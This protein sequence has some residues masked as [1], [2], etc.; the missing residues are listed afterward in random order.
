MQFALPWYID[1]DQFNFIFFSL[2]SHP[3][4]DLFEVLRKKITESIN[5]SFNLNA[6]DWRWMLGHLHASVG[7]ETSKH[8]FKKKNKFFFKR[9]R[10]RKT[11]DQKCHQIRRGSSAEGLEV[12]L[13]HIFLDGWALCLCWPSVCIWEKLQRQDKSDRASLQRERSV[14]FL[15]DIAI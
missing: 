7:L 5:P 2:F 3:W 8:K 15:L 10:N 13:I 12:W 4:R 6:A 11:I 9:K 1:W 14:S